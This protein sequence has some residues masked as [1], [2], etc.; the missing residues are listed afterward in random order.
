[1]EILV[2]RLKLDHRIKLEWKNILLKIDQVRM[3]NPNQLLTF[4]ILKNDQTSLKFV[5]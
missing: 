4:A 3:K 5:V 1:V 2:V